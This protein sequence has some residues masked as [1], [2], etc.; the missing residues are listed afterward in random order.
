[1]VSPISSRKKVP[2]AA[3]VNSPCLSFTAPVKAPFTWPNSSLSS[4]LSGSAPQLMD[5]NMCSERRD[6]SW[7]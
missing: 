2:L 6:K 3:A 4:R 7:M 5:E 1:V